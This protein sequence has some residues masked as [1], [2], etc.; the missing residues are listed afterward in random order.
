MGDLFDGYPADAGPAFDEVFAR[1][2]EPRQLYRRLLDAL[3]A[4][5]VG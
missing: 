2:G 5:E 4:L 1:S 3:R